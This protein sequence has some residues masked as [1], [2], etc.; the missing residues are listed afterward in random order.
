MSELPRGYGP[1]AE[2]DERMRPLTCE[3]DDCDPNPHDAEDDA[4]ERQRRAVDRAARRAKEIFGLGVDMMRA[5][6]GF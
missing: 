3:D 4:A 1:A 5:Q 2:D 6:R